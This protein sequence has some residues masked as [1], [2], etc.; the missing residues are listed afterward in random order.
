[1]S[2]NPN[3]L[4]YLKCLAQ[5][6]GKAAI[7]GLVAAAGGLT[8]TAARADDPLEDGPPAQHAEAAVEAKPAAPGPI[9]LF[10]VQPEWPR[11]AY[12]VPLRKPRVHRDHGSEFPH[13]PARAPYRAP[14]AHPEKPDYA[15]AP[16]IGKP[17]SYPEPVF[18]AEKDYSGR[19]D[20]PRG[21][22]YPKPPADFDRYEPQFYTVEPKASR[23]R[24]YAGPAPYAKGGGAPSRPY[25]QDGEAP[26]RAYGVSIGPRKPEPELPLTPDFELNRHRG[27]GRLFAV[28]DPY[29][30]G[31]GRGLPAQG[32]ALSELRALGQA[33]KEPGDPEDPAGDSDMPAGYTFL[34]QF[35]DHDL[36]LDIS[37]DISKGIRGD[38]VRNTRTPELDLDNVYG[39][40]PIATP[41]LFKLPY[42]RTGRPLA[43]DGAYIRHDLLRAESKQAPGPYGGSATAIIGDPR[44][45]ENF[46]IAQL[47][48]AFV[49]FH[50]RTVDVL[51]QRKFGRQR[52]RYCKSNICSIY[53]L[54]DGLPPAAKF[55]VF[56]KARDHVLHYYHRVIA[57]DFLPWMIGRGRTHD[58]LARGR[59]FYF[60]RGFRDKEG[61]LR[62]PYIPVEF[63][64]AAFRYGHSQVRGYYLL[65]EGHKVGLFDSKSGGLHAFQPLTRRHLVDWRY[66]FEIDDAPPSGFNWSRRIDPLITAALHQLHRNAVVGPADLGS[67]AARNLQRG[68]VFYLPSGQAVASEILPVLEQRGVLGGKGYGRKGP[69]G[70]WQSYLLPPNERVRA[71]LGGE[72][73][74]L[75]YYVLQEAATFGISRQVAYTPAY[76]APFRRGTRFEPAAYGARRDYEDGGNSLGPVGGTIVGEVLVGLLEHFKEKTGKG[77]AYQPD[78]RGSTSAYA[79]GAYGRGDKPRYLMRNLLM[80]AGVVESY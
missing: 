14:Y 40:G 49:A 25:A 45:D 34:G 43:E 55:E 39:G 3:L 19:R 15:A 1:M 2:K 8:T 11:K 28:L 59:D 9:N 78:V 80:D 18:E 68:R 38:E 76:A 33:L 5:P 50:N 22:G 16:P 72:E 7:F 6:L 74:P 64:A 67:L 46:I 44:D 23:G 70:A 51:V 26:Q 57:E 35:I 54:A 71:Y 58:L 62:D 4:R 65:R 47:H 24:G 77:L 73:T 12:P 41:Y 21:D 31:G 29:E 56:E 37:T 30:R 48:A 75:W 69:G 61:R 13:F 52:Y 27:F 66:F 36:T 32:S 17:E 53:R 10:V 63:A 42:L 20:H 60:P 79:G